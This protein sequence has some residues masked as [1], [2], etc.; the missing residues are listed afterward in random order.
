MDLI[1]ISNRI[2]LPISSF[3]KKYIDFFQTCDDYL[4]RF[5]AELS[6]CNLKYSESRYLSICRQYFYIYTLPSIEVIKDDFFEFTLNELIKSQFLLVLNARFADDVID[7]DN[8]FAD[9]ETSFYL[10][11]YTLSLGIELMQK[12][13]YFS[14]SD[15][16]LW[17]YY[18]RMFAFQEEMIRPFEKVSFDEFCS[19]HW[20][21][22]SMFFWMPEQAMGNLENSTENIIELKNFLKSYFDA[23]LSL[24]DILHIFN[25]FRFRLNTPA[26]LLFNEIVGHG[27]GPSFSIFHRKYTDW[28]NERF[29]SAQRIADKHNMVYSSEI[30]KS[31]KETFN[32]SEI[33]EL[34][35]SEHLEIY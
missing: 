28:V 7:N 20:E 31:L 2:S 30:L 8:N 3:K 11:H 19:R 16:T 33:E 17:K 32:E 29:E 1:Q 13:E 25:D 12:Q 9:Y 34:Y 14:F 23:A 21:R 6:R 22:G 24:G 10:S 27:M 18:Y 5:A 4:E 35:N 15:E 26:T